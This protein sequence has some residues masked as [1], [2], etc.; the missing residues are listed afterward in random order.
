MPFSAVVGHILEARLTSL[1][2]H[3]MGFSGLLMSYALALA[4]S[5]ALAFAYRLCAVMGLWC[6]RSS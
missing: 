1:V 3:P 2:G 6:I 4:L 5:S